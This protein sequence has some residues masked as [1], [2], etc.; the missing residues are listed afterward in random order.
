MKICVYLQKCDQTNMYQPG[1]NSKTR[2]GRWLVSFISPSVN[3]ISISKH[4]TEMA[5]TAICICICICIHRNI[6]GL[7]EKRLGRAHGPWRENGNKGDYREMQGIIEQLYRF[8]QIKCSL[9]PLK[10]TYCKFFFSFTGPIGH[11]IWWK[12][13]KTARSDLKMSNQPRNQNA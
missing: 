2:W 7:S 8:C 4:L 13:V 1:I 5:E 12:I 11:N 9:F 3:K 10:G 6:S